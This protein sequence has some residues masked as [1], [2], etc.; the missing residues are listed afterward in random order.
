M[1]MGMP[2]GRYLVVMRGVWLPLLDEASDLD[3]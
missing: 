2:C 3:T 1:L